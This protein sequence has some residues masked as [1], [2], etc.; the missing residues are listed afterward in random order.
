MLQYNLS[1]L[2][3]QP[4]IARPSLSIEDTEKIEDQGYRIL[5]QRIILQWLSY[6]MNMAMKALPH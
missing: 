6:D 1:R 2:P 5:V 3:G 4:R